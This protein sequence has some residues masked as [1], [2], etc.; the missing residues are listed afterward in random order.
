[1]AFFLGKIECKKYPKAVWYSMSREQQIKT[2]SKQLCIEARIAA[3]EAQLRVN[4]QPEEGDVIKKKGETLAEPAWERNRWSPMGTHQIL[5]WK[6][7][8]SG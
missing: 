6:C 3:L 4:S 1:M 5:G 7:K 8:E 2:A